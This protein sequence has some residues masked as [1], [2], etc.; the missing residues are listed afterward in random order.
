MCVMS[1]KDN[2]RFRLCCDQG[3]CSSFQGKLWPEGSL[4]PRPCGQHWVSAICLGGYV[5]SSLT[6]FLE[7]PLTQIRRHSSKLQCL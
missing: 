3:L 4:G 7:D 5:P 1:T 2:C 6:P